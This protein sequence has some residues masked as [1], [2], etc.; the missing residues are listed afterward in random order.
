MQ[1]YLKDKINMARLTM[2]RHI[3]VASSFGSLEAVC[4]ASM[5]KLL[6]TRAKSVIDI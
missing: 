1:P 5:E 4:R 6:G 2:E 3:I